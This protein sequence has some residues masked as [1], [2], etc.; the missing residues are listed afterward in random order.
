MDIS[1]LILRNVFFFHLFRGHYRVLY[2]TPEFVNVGSDILVNLDKK[3]GK[4]FVL[5][6]KIVRH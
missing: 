3:V 4:L 6:I 5:Y 1:C 2:L